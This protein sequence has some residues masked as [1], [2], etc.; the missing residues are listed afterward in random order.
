MKTRRDPTRSKLAAGAANPS[1]RAFPPAA[2][3]ARSPSP[4]PHGNLS[5]PIVRLSNLC[6]CVATA[7]PST[8]RE[9]P[10]GSV[11]SP[12]RSTPRSRAESS[13]TSVRSAPVSSSAVT[14]T[15]SIVAGMN[16]RSPVVRLS[17]TVPKRPLST[18]R[19]SPRNA[20]PATA[21]PDAPA[22]TPPDR[23][24][25]ADRPRSLSLKLAFPRPSNGAVGISRCTSTPPN[26]MLANTIGAVTAPPSPLMCACTSAWA[27]L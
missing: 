18:S 14:P 4:S 6:R 19:N 11:A 25:T 27:G 15:P 8:P 23:N 5:G 24:P 20:G 21:A 26:S 13:L 12:A 10:P 2:A 7:F 9:L 3:A 17:G 1:R 16:S 22:R